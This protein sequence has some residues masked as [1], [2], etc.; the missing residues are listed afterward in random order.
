LTV[1]SFVGK[2]VGT[3]Q[4]I[5]TTWTSLTSSTIEQGSRRRARVNR[6]EGSIDGGS[7][8]KEGGIPNIEVIVGLVEIADVAD[9]QRTVAGVIRQQVVSA[10]RTGQAVSTVIQ[11]SLTGAWQS[12]IWIVADCGIQSSQGVVSN[13]NIFFTNVQLCYIADQ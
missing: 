12:G 13:L 1:A 6:V 10:S 11:W 8:G 2:V 5:G 3:K 7:N 4:V 9:R